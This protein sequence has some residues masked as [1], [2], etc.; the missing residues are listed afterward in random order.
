M[1]ANLGLS[2]LTTI[3]TLILSKS[4]VDYE[5]GHMPMASDLSQTDLDIERQAL[6]SALWYRVFGSVLI[7]AVYVWRAFALRRGARGAYIRLY[8]I[9][10][11]GL[12]GIV[13]L[14]AVARYYP[15]WMR[16]EQVLQAAVL[17]GL[18]IA[19]SRKEVR[20]RFAKRPKFG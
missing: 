11:I 20:N 6:Q 13:Y 5:I 12:V 2:V 15:L 4:V 8:Y 17:V 16:A 14:I 3:L 19:V 18:L 9:G 1:F 10:I 7:S